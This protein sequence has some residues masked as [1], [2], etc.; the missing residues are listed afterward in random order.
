M[1]KSDLMGGSLLFRNNPYPCTVGTF[2]QQDILNQDG[3]GFSPMLLGDA[4]ILIA[5]LPPSTE[6]RKGESVT[7]TPVTGNPRDCY[8]HAVKYSG[9]MVSLLLRDIN[10]SA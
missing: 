8:I 3:G 4:Q 9:P 7:V 5:D 6:F 2:E 1:V 10:E